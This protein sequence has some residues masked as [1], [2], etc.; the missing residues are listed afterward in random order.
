MINLVLILLSISLLSAFLLI[1]MNTL[2]TDKITASNF[3]KRANIGF[4]TMKT[5]IMNYKK[6]YGSFP[7]ISTWESELYPD[8]GS[9]T[10]IGFGEWNLYKENND[11]FLCLSLES[12]PFNMSFIETIKNKNNSYIIKNV[13]CK[14]EDGISILQKI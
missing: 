11:I 3:E 7:N 14:N 10:E 2:S 13:D 4:N 9:K 5:Q 12:N 1:G 8:F 6:V